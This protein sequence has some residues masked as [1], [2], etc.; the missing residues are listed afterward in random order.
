LVLHEIFRGDA[1]TVA[2]IMEIAEKW[3]CSG[4]PKPKIKPLG[5]FEKWTITADQRKVASGSFPIGPPGQSPRRAFDMRY[6]SGEIVNLISGSVAPFFRCNMAMTRLL[7]VLARRAGFRLSAFG[8]LGSRFGRFL[9]RGALL[10]LRRRTLGTRGR[11]FGR[12]YGGNILRGSVSVEAL[13][14]LP[15]PSHGDVAALKLLHRLQVGGESG[16]SGER[17]PDGNES[18][19]GSSRGQRVQGF[20]A[21]KRLPVRGRLGFLRV[22]ER[23]DVVIEVDHKRCHLALVPLSAVNTSITRIPLK[24]K[25]ILREID[26][27]EG[28]AIEVRSPV[29]R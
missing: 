26:P 1:F 7:A 18:V 28:T 19:H 27:G 16:D 9:S 3:D 14:D 10:A 17:V 5:S 20:L 24:G 4:R 21:G 6:E 22:G 25:T 29:A 23:G 2:E 11:G 8:G 13:E 15:N 12:F